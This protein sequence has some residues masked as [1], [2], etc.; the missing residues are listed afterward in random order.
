MSP[1]T[2]N[3]FFPK[4]GIFRIGRLVFSR[5]MRVVFTVYVRLKINGISNIPKQPFIICSNHQSHLDALILSY[6]ASSNYSKT[7]M[8]AAKDYWYDSRK[9]FLIS[10]LFFNVLPLSRTDSSEN[11]RMRQVAAIAKDFIEE[12]GKCVV[13]LPEGTRSKSRKMMPFKNGVL[14]LSKLTGL[15]ILPVYI[16]GSANCWSKGKGWVKP[17]AVAATVGSLIEV[18]ELLNMDDALGIQQKV[19]ELAK[20]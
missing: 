10:R 8:I 1:R 14:M 12:N 6:L 5:F 2:S 9:R 4:N 3:Y 11:F 15:P 20:D 18:Q 7:I 13:I 16:K 19:I 17:G